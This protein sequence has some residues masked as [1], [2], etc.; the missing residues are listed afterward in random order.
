MDEALTT[1]NPEAKRA[2]PGQ[3][4]QFDLLLG[5]ARQLMEQSGEEW[6]QT[7]Q[8]DPV[9]GAVQLGTAT[10]RR[11]AQMSEEAGQPV[12]P[13]VLINVGVQFCKDIAAVANAAG[14]VPDEQLEQFLQD[15]M[16]QSIATYLQADADDGLL[17]EQDRAQAQ[18]VLQRMQGG[19]Q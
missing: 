5:R 18:N 2:S 11:L 19:P 3:Q 1:N 7:L 6:L 15:T 12:D 14:L 4:K 8:A 10:L 13:I 16:Q 9:E 17:G